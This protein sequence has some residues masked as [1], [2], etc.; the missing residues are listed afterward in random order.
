MEVSKLEQGV[1]ERMLAHAE[2]KPL[3][4]AVN[5]GAVRVTGRELTGAGFLTEFERSEELKLFDENTSLRWRQVG[6]RLNSNNLETSYLVYVDSG[7]LTAVEGSTYGESW[8]AEIQRIELYDLTP[9]M[10]LAG[11]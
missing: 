11:L 7:Y 10:E 5:F 4:L 3:K 1:I 8:P 9:G 6:A 2:L